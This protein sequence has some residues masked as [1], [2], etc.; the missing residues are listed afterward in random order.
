MPWKVLSC[1]DF[2]VNLHW[3]HFVNF[4]MLMALILSGWM[5]AALKRCIVLYGHVHPTTPN[6]QTQDWETGLILKLQNDLNFLVSG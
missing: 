1:G 4:L 5:N 3:H 6:I 2:I